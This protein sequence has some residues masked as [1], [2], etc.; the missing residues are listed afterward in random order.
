[1]ALASC[2]EVPPNFMTIIGA[3]SPCYAGLARARRQ[4]ITQVSLHLSNSAF[5]SAAPAAPRMVLWESTVNF[6]SN[7]P[8]GRRRPTVVSC[9]PRINVETRLRTVRCI[10]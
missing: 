8:Q 5:S 1:M 10:T 9:P 3:I 2:T 4:S 6:Q 7:T